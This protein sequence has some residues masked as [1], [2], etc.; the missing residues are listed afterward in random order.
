MIVL[1]GTPT[2]VEVLLGSGVSS[3][4][5]PITAHYVDVTDTTYK[6]GS[7]HTITTGTSAV[8]AVF[9]VGSGVRQVKLLTIYNADNANATVTVRLKFDAT[10][11]ILVK[12]T[13]AVAST[14]IYTDGEGFRVMNTSGQ[15]L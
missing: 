6:P 2:I 10:T 14:L 11:R 1:D 4:E 12:V 5:L 9:T 3:V 8:T 7:F 13:L 15:I